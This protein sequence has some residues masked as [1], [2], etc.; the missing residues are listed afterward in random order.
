MEKM[1][2][3]CSKIYVDTNS[4][5]RGSSCEFSKRREHMRSLVALSGILTLLLSATA[6]SAGG[7]DLSTPV[8]RWTV[9]DEKSGY[10]SSIIEIWDSGGELQGRVLKL[11]PHPGSKS[12][13]AICS[14]CSGDLKDKPIVGMTVMKGLKKDG[15]EWNGGSIL[16][17]DSGDSYS[18]IL[19]LADGGRKLVLRGYI[20]ISLI[21]RSMTWS[22]DVEARQQ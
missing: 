16:D 6:A 3:G 15:D 18:L 9:I 20:G 7:A 11:I 2:S 19:R 5:L 4:A 12:G 13:P 10:P 22:R 8:G 21:G 17:T 14:A 1:G